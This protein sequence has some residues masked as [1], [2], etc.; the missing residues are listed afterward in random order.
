MKNKKFLKELRRKNKRKILKSS[1]VQE[2]IRLK[3]LFL[4]SKDKE[5]VTILNYLQKK[6]Y[7][8]K[9]NNIFEKEN[10]IFILKKLN[11]NKDI[12]TYLP[13]ELKKLVSIYWIEPKKDWKW[14]VFQIVLTD[15]EKKIEFKAIKIDISLLEKSFKNK[16]KSWE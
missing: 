12:T 15:N 16:D 7:I 9:E 2:K 5:T 13:W 3:N 4:D 10:N 1:K 14:E 11:I 6:G 8:L